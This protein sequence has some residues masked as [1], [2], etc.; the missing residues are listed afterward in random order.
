MKLDPLPIFRNE[1]HHKYYWQPTQEWLAYSTTG[2]TGAKKSPEQ[3]AKFEETKHIWGPRGTYVHNC[4]EQFML[5]NKN[6][7]PGD[8]AD[9]VEPLLTHPYWETFEPW[10]V[11]YMLCDLKKSV[12]GQLDLLGYDHKNKQVVLLDL[13]TQSSIR[14]SKYSTDAQMGSYVQ[15]LIDHHKLAVDSCRT[16][17]ARPKKAVL[18]PHQDVDQ[19]SLAWSEA[20]DFFKIKQSII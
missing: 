4:L 7:D 19:C 20:W 1:E 8:Y 2:I 9:W 11:E 5:G 10:A 13:K 12:G 14:A 15:G 3:I 6:P 18:G 16:M 17:W